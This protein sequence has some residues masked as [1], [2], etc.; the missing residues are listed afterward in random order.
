[1]LIL[2][3]IHFLYDNNRTIGCKL[4]FWLFHWYPW[5][6]SCT[7]KEFPAKS[8]RI[9]T[10]PHFWFSFSLFR[11]WDCDLAMKEWEVISCNCS[12]NCSMNSSS[13]ILQEISSALSLVVHCWKVISKSHHIHQLNY[14]RQPPWVP[15]Q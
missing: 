11:Y 5:I 7:I 10:S 12:H 6:L 13:G 1:M 9:I 8:P 15:L 2:S 14:H 3:Q 4:H